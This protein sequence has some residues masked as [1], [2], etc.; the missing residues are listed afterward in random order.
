MYYFKPRCTHCEEVFSRQ[1]TL[2]YINHDV[3]PIITVD[4]NTGE[5]KHEVVC[6][7]CEEKERKKRI[8]AIKE[9]LDR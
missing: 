8:T 7:E 9:C 2:D 1:R 6:A 5:I 3:I 4:A